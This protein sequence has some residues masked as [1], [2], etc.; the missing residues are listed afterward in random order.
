[1]LLRHK[2]A[3]IVKN[4]KAKKPRFKVNQVQEYWVKLKKTVDWAKA[5]LGI[6]PYLDLWCSKLSDSNTINQ[7]S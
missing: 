4:S 2:T 1:M 3:S 7:I 5:V 6:G